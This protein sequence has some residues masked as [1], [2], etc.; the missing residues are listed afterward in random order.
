MKE[1]TRYQYQK[2]IAELEARVRE[3]E[4][5]Q[6]FGREVYDWLVGCIGGTPNI[7]FGLKLFRQKGLL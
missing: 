7:A 5:W 4:R 1:A 2:R 3:L 6:S